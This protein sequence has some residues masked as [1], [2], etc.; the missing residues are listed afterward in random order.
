MINNYSNL[1]KLVVEISKFFF[2]YSD[3]LYQRVFGVGAGA[4]MVLIL[5]KFTL[6]WFFNVLG[7][8]AGFFAGVGND[9]KS[10]NNTY[11]MKQSK[12]SSADYKEGYKRGVAHNKN[13]GRK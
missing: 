5:I 10:Y 9:I 11:S 2:E 12:R 1:L 7:S 6:H 8:S 4:I 3:L 13:K